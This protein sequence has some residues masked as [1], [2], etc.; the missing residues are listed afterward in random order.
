MLAKTLIWSGA[1]TIILSILGVFAVIARSLQQAQ[2][3]ANAGTGSIGAPAFL[4]A[5]VCSFLFFVGVLLLLVGL[6]KF[7]RG[8]RTP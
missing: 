1:V 6:I 8:K 4:L 7:S 2:F 5:V 3:N